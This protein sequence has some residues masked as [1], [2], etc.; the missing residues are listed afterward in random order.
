VFLTQRWSVSQAALINS[1]AY[2]KGR[3]DVEFLVVD[4]IELS[5]RFVRYGCRQIQRLL[6]RWTEGSSYTSILNAPGRWCINTL[7]A[8][9]F[10]QVAHA[11]DQWGFN[12]SNG[13]GNA[14]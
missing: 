2:A 8:G 6:L 9:L 10:F 3:E 14:T 1:V 13:L 5:L 7:V 4:M 12:E 11:R